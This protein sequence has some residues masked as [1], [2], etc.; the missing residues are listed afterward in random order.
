M[1]YFSDDSDESHR[2]FSFRKQ[3]GSHG[4]FSFGWVLQ[5]YKLQHTDY[6]SYRLFPY[7]W[8]PQLLFINNKYYE[9]LLFIWIP[10][11]IVV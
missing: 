10:L 1:R 4:Y 11:G 2:E 3:Y 6:F 9:I 8:V 7:G 5:P